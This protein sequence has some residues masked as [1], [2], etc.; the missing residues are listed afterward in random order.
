MASR[1]RLPVENS[2]N[3]FSIDTFRA[4]RRSNPTTYRNVRPFHRPNWLTI[5]S[6]RRDPSRFPFCLATRTSRLDARICD[7]VA[8]YR[9]PFGSMPR[10]EDKTDARG[11]VRLKKIPMRHSILASMPTPPRDGVLRT[12]GGERD[13]VGTRSFEEHRDSASDRRPG[14]RC[15][16]VYSRP[17]IRRA[18]GWCV[19]SNTR[20]TKITSPHRKTPW[21]A[22]Q[23]KLQMRDLKQLQ[24]QS[25][26]SGTLLIRCPPMGT[27]YFC[28]TGAKTLV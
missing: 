22:W 2:H 21:L 13:R 1:S 8:P 28:R 15:A 9:Y 27:N 23:D 26:R 24:S 11:R 18:C 12:T 20:Q 6:S 4:V 5:H 25:V 10:N 19:P 7:L 14:A 17:P 3:K 16:V